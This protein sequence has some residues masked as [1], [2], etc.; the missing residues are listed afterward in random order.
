MKVI[1]NWADLTIAA[2]DLDS[3]TGIRLDFQ[4][5]ASRLFSIFDG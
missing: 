4:N 2:F 5:Q 1:K 3:G